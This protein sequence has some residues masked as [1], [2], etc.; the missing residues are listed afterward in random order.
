VNDHYTEKGVRFTYPV[1][2]FDLAGRCAG[3]T[4][5]KRWVLSSTI[6]RTKKRGGSDSLSRAWKR[7]RLTTPQRLVSSSPFE[8]DSSRF[9]NAFQTANT[10]TKRGPGSLLPLRR[11]GQVQFLRGS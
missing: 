11:S 7:A 5:A 4:L 10:N 9:F 3:R 6:V 2:F 1:V 8:R